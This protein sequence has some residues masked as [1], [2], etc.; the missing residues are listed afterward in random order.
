MAHYPEW[1]LKH[2]RKGTEIRKINN[3]FYL[4]EITSRWNKEKKRPV[5]ITKGLVG[6]ISEEGLVQSK[7]RRLA[8]GSR[9]ITIKEFGAFHYVWEQSQ[10]LVQE[11]KQYF[12]DWWK[13]LWLAAYFRLMH[14]SPLKH[15]DLHY[16]TTFASEILKSA[17]L[18]DKAITAW[19][20]E[21]GMQRERITGFLKCFLKGHELILMDATHVISLSE[22]VHDSQ[23]G[24]NS[25]RQ[26]DP[27]VNLLFIYAADK[28]LPVYYRLLP[29]NIRE[30]KALKLTI[31][32]SGL[33]QAIVVTDKGFYSRANLRSLEAAQLRYLIPLRRNSKL[34]DYRPISV[35]AKQGFDG[36][37]RFQDRII[38][39]HYR[40][41]VW[42]FLDEELK[43]MEQH[44]YLRR[45]E[46]Q[47]SFYTMEKFHNK[48]HEFGTIAVISNV[49]EVSA[50]KIFEFLKS[51]M[52]VEVML[53]AYKNILDADRTY[54][55]GNCEM[56]AWT[57]INYLA[58][59]FYYRIYQSLLE[60]DILKKYGPKDFLL[61]LSHI[62]KVRILNEWRDAECPN[63]LQIFARKID[64][65]LPI[66]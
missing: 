19:L 62:K 14:Q 58:L 46:N 12:P 61:Y 13:E 3:A 35:A 16:Q 57:F 6:R 23:L 5:K 65:N 8:E 60:K 17:R 38:W 2:K 44:D 36:Y 9:H 63:K 45:V 41:P 22:G 64:L 39:H 20:R 37:F 53:D 4:Y 24:Y 26:F 10:D 47:R 7:S 42:L 29:G 54:M 33:D 28:K 50:Q 31:Q 43:N 11:L 25:Q 48:N 32:E 49:S 52:A 18:H 55:R 56:E 34:I 27:Q 15:F 30:I 66:T 40:H 59:L 51:R 1:V 21:I